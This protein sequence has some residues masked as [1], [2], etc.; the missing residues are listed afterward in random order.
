MALK[1]LPEKLHQE[2]QE[3]DLLNRENPR[4]VVNLLPDKLRERVLEIFLTHKDYF[5]KPEG[6]L[7]Q[8]LKDNHKS[9]KKIDNILRLKFWLE[10]DRVQAFNKKKMNMSFIM[11]GLVDT[12]FF[13]N[14]Y[15]REPARVAWLFCPP[16]N[17]VACLEEAMYTNLDGLHEIASREIVDRHNNFDHKIASLKIQLFKTLDERL[18]GSVIQRHQI[19]EEKHVKVVMSDQRNVTAHIE[20][21]NMEALQKRILDL[22]KQ[23]RT[24]SHLP[25][26]NKVDEGSV[27]VSSALDMSKIDD[28]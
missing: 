23:D 27:V 14:W 21:S 13:H 8:L 18:H 2:L 26:E 3:I 6:E 24:L 17:Y 4:S 20:G 25:N 5:S 22:E 1:N 12:D 9:P 10:Y 16:V 28:A 15:F 19:Q 7:K 11:A